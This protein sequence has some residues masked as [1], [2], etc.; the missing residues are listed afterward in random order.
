MRHIS[1]A[2]LYH[3][4]YILTVFMWRVYSTTMSE[5]DEG[6]TGFELL[7][8]EPPVEAN[9]ST[10]L[11]KPA[12]LGTRSSVAQG[13]LGTMQTGPMLTGVGGALQSGDLSTLQ[14]TSTAAGAG[15]LAQKQMATVA[16]EG[17][18]AAQGKSLF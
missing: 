9:S 3:V 5:T 11:V 15:G 2:D 4:L 18:A 8:E 1:P 12:L 13:T 6:S 16:A 17:T 14:N 7:D 10:P